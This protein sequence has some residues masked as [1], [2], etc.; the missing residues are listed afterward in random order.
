LGRYVSQILG[1]AAKESQAKTPQRRLVSRRVL[2]A[3]ASKFSDPALVGQVIKAVID[4]LS[5][6]SGKLNAWE[7]RASYLHV[8]RAM[9]LFSGLADADRHAAL[10]G[11]TDHLIVFLKKEANAAAR[12]LAFAVLADVSACLPQVN[13]LSPN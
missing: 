4:H 13:L 2:A 8:V 11:L 1:P 6:K 3:L 10:T 7:E 5:G 9:T 12:S